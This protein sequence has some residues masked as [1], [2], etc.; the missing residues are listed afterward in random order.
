[1]KQWKIC[2]VS[3]DRTFFRAFR[4]ENIAVQSS[5]VVLDI[6]PKPD[7]AGT[8]IWLPATDVAV[9]EDFTPPKQ[10]ISLGEALT[11]TVTVMAAG[12]RDSQI[13]DL[14]F[15]DGTDYKQYP[16]KTDSKICLTTTGLS[17]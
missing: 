5:A 13:P 8:G 14:A 2:S 11:R 10:T 17:A 9:S 1:M 4:P 15:P 7:Q 12:V 3:A 16:G 6:R